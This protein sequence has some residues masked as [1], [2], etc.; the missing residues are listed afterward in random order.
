MRGN[1]IKLLK[2]KIGRLQG[3]SLHDSWVGE[4]FLNSTFLKINLKGEDWLI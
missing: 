4:D 2:N 3:K 1:I